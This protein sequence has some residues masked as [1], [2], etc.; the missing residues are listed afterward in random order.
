M[1]PPPLAQTA[2][3][4]LY[5][6]LGS[7]VQ[8]CADVLRFFLSYDGDQTVQEAARSLPLITFFGGSVFYDLLSSLPSPHFTPMALIPSRPF[9]LFY[10]VTGEG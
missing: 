8:T 9:Q 1:A 7:Q 4:Q 5:S 3:P 10:D 2:R 6:P